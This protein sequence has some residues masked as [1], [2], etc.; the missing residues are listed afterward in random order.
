MP[1]N[2]NG[3]I[4]T[5]GTSLSVTD[6]SSNVLYRQSTAGLVSKPT[7]SSGTILTP[8]FN[9]GMGTDT[10]RDLG[11]VVIFNYTGGSG[12][13]NINSCYNTSNGAFT[14]PFTGLYLFKEHIYI[15]GIDGSVYTYYTHPMYM[16]NGSMTLRR[17]GGAVYRMRLFGLVASYG[18]DT[19][20]SELI[21]LTA[22]DYVQ[23]YCPRN[24]TVQGYPPYSTFNGSYISN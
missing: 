9:V 10:W 22:G 14:A 24:G 23:V 19:D 7:N 8:M 12:Y 11:G 2:V 20:C 6:A 17:P 21:Y 15:Y 5:G 13:L 18:F 1:V 16:V 3:T 4:L